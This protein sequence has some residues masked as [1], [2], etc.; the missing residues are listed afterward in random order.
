MACRARAPSRLLSLP[1]GR[2]MGMAWLPPPPTPDRAVPPTPRGHPLGP[3][4]PLS[5]K[6]AAPLNP[7]LPLPH[8]PASSPFYF[9]MN[10]KR[11]RRSHANHAAPIGCRRPLPPSRPQW[12]SAERRAGGR[13]AALQPIRRRGRPSGGAPLGGAEGKQAAQGGAGRGGGRWL[14][15]AGGRRAAA[16]CPGAELRLLRPRPRLPPARLAAAEPEPKLESA[17]P[18]PGTRGLAGR[19]GAGAVF[20]NGAGR[21]V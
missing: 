14:G 10:E 2:F 8:P 1:W 6:A 12:C 16:R 17:A 9:F 7:A 4:A 15:G 5:E 21:A 19:R 13:A 11:S 20:M 18:R 3:P